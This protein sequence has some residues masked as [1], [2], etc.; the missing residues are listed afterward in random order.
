MKS[1]TYLLSDF[2]I[3]DAMCMGRC[4][5][6]KIAFEHEDEHDFYRSRRSRRSRSFPALQ[7]GLSIF[8]E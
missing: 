2:R 6:H 8:D 4:S 7:K 1:P 5:R 3:Q